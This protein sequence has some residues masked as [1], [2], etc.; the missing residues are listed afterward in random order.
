VRLGDRPAPDAGSDI[1]IED[2]FEMPPAQLLGA[3][4]VGMEPM[5]V[6]PHVTVSFDRV[7]PGTV[8]IRRESAVSS[9]DGHHVGHVVALVLD[10]HGQV[11]RLVLEHGHLWGKRELE[12]PGASIDRI[13]SDEVVLALAK[14]EVGR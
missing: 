6:D 10:D 13:L 2:G 3:I 12:I 14:D 8:E 4:G 1:G 11:A 7:P 5:D 9:A